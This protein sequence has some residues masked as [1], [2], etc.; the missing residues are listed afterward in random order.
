VRDNQ[1]FG[2]HGLKDMKERALLTL[3]N[4]N[5]LNRAVERPCVLQTLIDDCNTQRQQNAVGIERACGYLKQLGWE[6]ADGAPASSDADVSVDEN[7]PYKSN[8]AASVDG[9]EA[10]FSEVVKPGAEFD[11]IDASLSL[12]PAH[13]HTYTHTHTN[14]DYTGDWTTDGHTGSFQETAAAPGAFA[15]PERTTSSHPT[16]SASA[17]DL[18]KT[19]SLDDFGGMSEFTRSMLMKNASSPVV[20]AGLLSPE[21]NPSCSPAPTATSAARVEVSAV[22]VFEDRVSSEQPDALATEEED[23][24]LSMCHTV[25]T[26]VDEE[27]TQKDEETK[28]VEEELAEEADSPTRRLPTVTQE[29][30]DEVDVPKYAADGISL[31]ELNASIAKISEFVPAS[32]SYITKDEMT[33]LFGPDKFKVRVT[34]MFLVRVHVLTMEEQADGSIVYALAKN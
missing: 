31:V 2:S 1:A 29:Q 9:D 11:A 23:A 16:A 34:H 5:A 4:L 18:L 3:E 30:F 17:M 22:P 25:D 10:V 12:S 19:P 6:G 7:T 15:S 32:R 28:A 21:S 13:T 33:M 14:E 27:P 20:I 24:F 26:N 8:D